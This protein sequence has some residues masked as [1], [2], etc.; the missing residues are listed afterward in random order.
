MRCPFASRTFSTVRRSRSALR[1]ESRTH[2]IACAR[3]CTPAAR[4]RSCRVRDISERRYLREGHPARRR[5]G[6]C[7]GRPFRADR[8][9][10]KPSFSPASTAGREST[11]R[12]TSRFFRARTA[13]TIA[14]IGF[15]RSGRS[16]ADGKRVARD[17]AHELA[18]ARRPRTNFFTAAGA[19][20]RRGRGLT[21]A[22]FARVGDGERDVVRRDVRALHRRIQ[23]LAQA[24]TRL[25][26]R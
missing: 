16:D 13:I 12:V 6:A 21:A 24:R 26:R 9:A 8:R 4:L 7:M 5:A 22:A 14:K 2:S 11:T 18:L 1:R 23:H 3:A 15:A 25:A 10:R 17:R 20:Q 19:K